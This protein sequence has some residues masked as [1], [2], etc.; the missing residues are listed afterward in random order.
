LVDPDKALGY[1]QALSTFA[2]IVGEAADAQRLLQNAAAQV[3]R[4]T[5]IKHVKVLRYRPDQGDLLIE[6]GVG[7]HPGV[8]GHVSFGADRH[9]SPGRSLQ[10]GAPV[11]CIDIRNDPEFRYADVLRE[12]GIISVC[13]VP[14][15]VDGKHWGVLEVDTEAKTSFEDFDIHSLSIFADII[16]LSLAHRFA[17]ADA[18]Q[19]ASDTSVSRTQSEVLMRELQHRMKNNLQVIV[20]F[21]ALQRRQSTS[22]EARERIA[23]VMDRVLAIGLAHDQLSFKDSASAV[24]MHDYLKA[25]C[26]NIDPHRPEVS[27]EV[28]VDVASIPLERTADELGEIRIRRRG[29]HH[30]CRVSGER[31]HRRGR[32]LGARQ[33][34]RLG[35]RAAGRFR[36]AS[37]RKPRG[38]ARRNSHPRR[39]AEGH[40]DNAAISLFTLTTVGICAGVPRAHDTECAVTGES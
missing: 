6:A 14:I 27:V 23:A 7:W 31:E 36:P 12:H 3:A 33:W 4:I 16:G 38:A 26:A 20:S 18:L 13:N 2:R 21:L 8:V 30:Q 11:V 37:G 32:N 17:Q 5:H 24:S 1:Q 29:W 35:R 40:T 9:S 28:D 19:A 39:R 34:P 15:L 22:E 10:T 25:L